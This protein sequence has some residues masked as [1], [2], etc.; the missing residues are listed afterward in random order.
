M[1]FDILDHRLWQDDITQ[2]QVIDKM[3]SITA[4]LKLQ[5]S[6]VLG[7]ELFKLISAVRSSPNYCN[8]EDSKPNW[9]WSSVMKDDNI[10][11]SE[12][13]RHVIRSAMAIP[14]GSASTERTFS[15][16]NFIKTAQRAR[17]TPENMEHILRIRINGP[18]MA[19]TEIKNYANDWLRDHERCNPLFPKKKAR[20]S[21]C[22]E[23]ATLFFQKRKQGAVI[24]MKI[25]KNSLHHLVQFLARFLETIPLFWY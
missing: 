15:I 23:D 9:F 22:D 18:D 6:R 25:V 24:V 16:M 4:E 8:M 3:A 17:L 14:M 21:D 1:D 12:E 2:V 5:R 13:L 20:S 7:K 11:I 10:N 19:V